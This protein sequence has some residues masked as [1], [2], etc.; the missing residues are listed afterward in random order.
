MEYTYR[1]RGDCRGFAPTMDE[2][3]H[4]S[5]AMFP[6][7][8]FVDLAIPVRGGD[9]RCQPE[10][11]EGFEGAVYWETDTGNHGWAC[12]SCGEVIQWG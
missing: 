10:E 1:P 6:D 12:E 8:T 7:S 2:M 11:H 4:A 9:H 5:R 3:Q